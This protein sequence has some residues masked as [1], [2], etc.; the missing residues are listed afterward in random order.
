MKVRKWLEKI[1]ESVRLVL[2]MLIGYKFNFNM[3]YLVMEFWLKLIDCKWIDI[4][5]VDR[6]GVVSC[7]DYLELIDDSCFK[8]WQVRKLYEDYV[9]WTKWNYESWALRINESLT[10]CIN[11]ELEKENRMVVRKKWLSDEYVRRILT[12]IDSKGLDC[13]E[14]FIIDRKGFVDEIE[15]D[16][17]MGLIE[18]YM[19]FVTDWMADGTPRYSTLEECENE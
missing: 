7:G 16:D 18:D 3:T 6:F 12:R 19:F 11:H 9:Y 15:Y 8:V 5:G 14:S 2:A 4:D 10:E 13:I 17:A 1:P